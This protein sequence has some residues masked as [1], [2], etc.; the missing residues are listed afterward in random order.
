MASP[1]CS[2]TVS[3]R[4]SMAARSSPMRPPPSSLKRWR[5]R[6]RRVIASP[7]RRQHE[8]AG[9][10]LPRLIGSAR[11]EGAAAVEADPELLQPSAVAPVAAAHRHHCRLEPGIGCCKIGH[12]I[13]RRGADRLLRLMIPRRDLDLRIELAGEREIGLLIEP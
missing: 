6:A 11:D 12:E 10:A 1:R 4:T 9:P 13:G 3:P 7:D 5:K 2:A 8:F